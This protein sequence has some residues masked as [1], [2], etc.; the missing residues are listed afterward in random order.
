MLKC[1][2][3]ALWSIGII[4]SERTAVSSDAS[5]VTEGPIAPG[6]IGLISSIAERRYLEASVGH[7]RI[8][9]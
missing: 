9:C 1:D 7:R 3:C 2:L 4:V 8:S 5:A 6:G